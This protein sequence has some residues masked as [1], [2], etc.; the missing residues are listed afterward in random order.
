MGDRTALQITIAECP[1]SEVEDVLNI[2]SEYG[3]GE[4]DPL[5]LGVEYLN[6]EISCGS[7]DELASALRE[8][9]PGTSF[10]VWE[11][12][13]Y[14]WLGSLNVTAEGQ[15]FGAECDANGQA[16]WTSEQVIKV[17]TDVSEVSVLREHLGLHIYDRYTE[18]QDANEGKVLRRPAPVAIYARLSVDGTACSETAL[19]TNH[20][21]QAAEFPG[22]QTGKDAAVTDHVD[23]SGNDE[24]RCNVCGR[25]AS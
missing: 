10:E 7:S 16:L 2:L 23:C 11:D 24:L 14:E 19:C 12:P 1:E 20:L 18:L 22:D 25:R 21:S 4:D 17:F 6:D 13:K 9:A 3:L 15:H 5:T 8:Q